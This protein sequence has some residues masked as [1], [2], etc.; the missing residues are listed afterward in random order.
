[1]LI[2]GCAMSSLL[3]GLSLVLVNGGCSVRCVGFSL[4]QLLLLWSTG[5]M[6]HELQ[7]LWPKGFVALQTVRSSQIS[8][9]SISSAL[10]GGFFTSEPLGKP[11]NFLEMKIL[12]Y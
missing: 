3:C 9:G 5:S 10:A 8:N 2:F 11:P 7:Q 12:C 1:M 6:A 4:G